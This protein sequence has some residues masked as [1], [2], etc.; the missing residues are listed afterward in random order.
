MASIILRSNVFAATARA[1]YA[2]IAAI[3]VRLAASR[4]VVVGL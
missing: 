3:K 4:E 1:R 2:V